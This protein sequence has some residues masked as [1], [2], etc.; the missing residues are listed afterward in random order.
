MG[1]EEAGE[2]LEA[3]ERTNGGE[4]KRVG[5]CKCPVAENGQIIAPR[6]TPS[7]LGTPV[8]ITTIAAR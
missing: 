8:I 2:A 7:A 1:V 4:R 6:P 5:V 3:N